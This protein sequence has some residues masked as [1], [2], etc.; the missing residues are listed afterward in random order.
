LGYEGYAAPAGARS[1]SASSHGVGARRRFVL[2]LLRACTAACHGSIYL[3]GSEEQS[4]VAA[5]D[6]ALEK[7]GC[8]GRPSHWSVG[9]EQEG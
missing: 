8:F 6:G 4:E 3:D 1:C 5:A 9:H 7:I 2:H